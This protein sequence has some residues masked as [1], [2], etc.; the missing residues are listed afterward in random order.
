MISLEEVRQTVISSFQAIHEVYY[1]S[2][3]VDYP[4]YQ[5]VDIE[6]QTAPFIKVELMFD[7]TPRAA[8]GERDILVKGTLYAYF[9]FR[10]GAGLSGAYS[11]TDMLNEYLA[12]TLTAG[13]QYQAVRTV[14]IEN[15]PGWKGV[16][17]GITFDVVSGPDC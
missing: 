12:M 8:L 2:T 11:Y 9:Y 1:P 3:L 10:K 6:R 17:N 14:N 15:F 5:V 16:M 7:E 13:I 4:N